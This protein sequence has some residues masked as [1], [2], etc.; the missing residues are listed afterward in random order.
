[1]PYLVGGLEHFLFSP[2][3]GMMIQSD[4]YVSE[5]LKPHVF[6]PSPCRKKPQKKPYFPG[7]HQTLGVGMVPLSAG[8]RGK[9]TTPERYQ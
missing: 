4:E 5:G 7:L 2:I 6:A 3:A 8:D 9:G 1:M